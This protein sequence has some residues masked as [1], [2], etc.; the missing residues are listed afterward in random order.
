MKHQAY[1]LIVVGTGFAS[2]FFLKKYLSKAPNSAKVLVLERGFLFPHAER[3]KE[4]RGEDTPFATLN[5][6]YQDAIVNHNPEKHWMFQSAFGG[7]SNCWFGCT[8]RFLPSD[9]RMKSLYG[10]G[11]DWQV[12]YNELDDY[13]TEVE[14]AMSISGPEETPFPRK[15]AYP[16][17]PHAFTTV[18]KVLKEKWGNLYINQPTARARVQ[19][20][21]RGVCC[22][23]TVCEICP[24][25]AKF[26]IE[27]SGIGVYEDARVELLT[28]AQ[29][30]AVD[31]Q[32]DVVK[33]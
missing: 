16:Q 4:K 12:Q 1:D 15:R 7:G 6:H 5:M 2:T 17:P 20:K 10:V 11:S 29:V 33:A 24:V 8:P 23:S 22:G 21:N 18:D 31:L 9:F 28:G 3:V 30:W 32:Q 27:N 19:T 26:T 25:D 14:E 13:Y